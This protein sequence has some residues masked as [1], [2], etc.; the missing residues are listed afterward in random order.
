MH[1]RKH[2]RGIKMCPVVRY[3]MTRRD[4]PVAA[5][6]AGGDSTLVTALYQEHRGA[7]FG[8]V[9]RLTGGDQQ[10]AEDVVQETLFRA[11]RNADKLDDAPGLLRA[12]LF[13]VAR[14]IVIDGHRSKGARPPETEAGPLELVAVPDGTDKTLSAMVVAEALRSLSPEHREAI[15][16]TYLKDRTVN[17]A[18]EVLGVPP[19]TVKSRVYYALRALRRA[20][21]DRGMTT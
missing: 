9:L 8:H 5:N 21:Q 2:V 13:T 4:Q 1:F 7:L 14:R 17:E 11:W 19:G 10:W 18:A 12:W 15:L 16:Q 3:R 20:L 6:A